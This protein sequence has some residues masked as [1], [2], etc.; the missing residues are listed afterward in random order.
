MWLMDSDLEKMSDDVKVRK[1]MVVVGRDS[2]TK[3]KNP[4]DEEWSRS[5]QIQ[6]HGKPRK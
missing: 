6:E 2:R 5:N 4:E 3:Q 1:T